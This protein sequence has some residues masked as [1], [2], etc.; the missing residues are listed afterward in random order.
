MSAKLKIASGCEF[1]TLFLDRGFVHKVCP[2]DLGIVSLTWQLCPSDDSDIKR[3]ESGLKRGLCMKTAPAPRLSFPSNAMARKPAVIMYRH[4]N[5][6][7]PALRAASRLTG[8]HRPSFSG[9]KSGCRGKNPNSAYLLCAKTLLPD[10]CS[11][12]EPATALGAPTGHADPSQSISFLL[13][14]SRLRAFH[15]MTRLTRLPRASR[16]KTLTRENRDS[17]RKARG[18]SAPVPVGIDISI[19]PLNPGN[20]TRRS[21]SRLRI[22]SV[23][24][25]LKM[26]GKRGAADI[27]SELP[28][29]PLEAA[30]HIFHYHTGNNR[31]ENKWHQSRKVVPLLFHAETQTM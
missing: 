16:V 14:P 13:W 20:F 23:S 25:R 24:S 5:V 27:K 11:K 7:G 3:R 21:P 15:P 22:V 9:R 28:E 29:L 1:I 26:K 4:H 30:C 2:H 8:S 19:S 18:P 17:C 12:N 10:Q 6:E 31:E